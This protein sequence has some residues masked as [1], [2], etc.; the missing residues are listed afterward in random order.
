MKKKI[1]GDFYICISVPL[2]DQLFES[3]APYKN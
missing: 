1:S 3:V 2:I